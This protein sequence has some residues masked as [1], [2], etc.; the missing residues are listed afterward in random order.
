MI[1]R[2]ITGKY[3]GRKLEAPEDYN[4]RPTTDKVKEAVFDILMND[5]YGSTCCDLF[6][7]SGSLGIEALSRGA[8]MCWFCDSDR[9]SIRL[10]K[11]NI[12]IVGASSEA[13]VVTG[14]YKK[15]LRKIDGKIDIFFVD[16][17]Y[18]S[19]LY[20]TVLSQIDILDLLSDE[21]I[22]ITEHDS[23]QDM[24]DQIGNLVKTK[25]KKYGR[26]VLSLYT[27]MK[28]DKL[29]GGEE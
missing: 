7:G 23:R 20:E 13:R 22:I 5:I 9:N 18:E 1:L 25:V 15:C 29:A 12:S 28:T 26:T 6:A 14:D 27:K 16:P 19:G 4:V 3:K 10:I 2:V 24:P 11:K 8:Q 17:P 21:G